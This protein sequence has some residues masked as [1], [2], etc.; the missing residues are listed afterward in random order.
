MKIKQP[1]FVL[2]GIAGSVVFF[3][4]CMLLILIG[5]YILLFPGI[6]MVY[7]VNPTNLFWMVLA[8]LLI[9]FSGLFYV[10]R[11]LY[12]HPDY[13]LA[14]KNKTAATAGAFLSYIVSAAAFIYFITNTALPRPVRIYICISILFFASFSFFHLF[15]FF[16]YFFLIRLFRNTLNLSEI[17]SHKSTSIKDID[18]FLSIHSAII[19]RCKRTGELL[20]VT[21]IVVKN[22]DEINNQYGISG[23]S[24]VL[25]QFDFILTEHTRNYEPWGVLT[26]RMLFFNFF[27]V[28][29]ENEMSQINNRFLTILNNS[30]FMISDTPVNVTCTTKTV[31]IRPD[32]L[33][34]T[35]FE[36][37]EI[38][39]LNSQI[40]LLL[41]QF[42][43]SQRGSD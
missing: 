38:D 19:N 15:H 29:D 18:H 32:E 35:V 41:E 33:P 5:I 10:R 39:F 14:Y 20:A 16:V 24:Q 25:R 6:Q 23:I 30:E 27:Q 42:N 34:S 17:I 3:I 2:L 12:S 22:R 21:G 36:T 1:S 8:T 9:V 31:I 43:N 4:V 11:N 28:S 7:T 40:S 37:E 13:F 26:E